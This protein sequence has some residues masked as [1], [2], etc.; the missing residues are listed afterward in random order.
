MPVWLI[1]F[2]ILL[3]RVVDVSIGTLRLVF[4]SRG[5][6]WLAPLAG[7]FEVLIWITAIAQIMRNLDNWVAYVA[8]AGGFAAGTWIGMWFEEKLALGTVLL[9][10]IPQADPTTLAGR[11][12]DRGYR[13]TTVDA[14]GLRGP[15]KILFSVIRRTDLPKAL[16]LVRTFN[17][18]AF[19][20]IEDVRSANQPD[21][22][23][24]DFPEPRKRFFSWRLGK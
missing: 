15:V 20:T 8:Y 1:P 18:R 2:L 6:K 11:L 13:V 24:P 21:P 9:R 4:V 5:M 17:P 16:A 10:I 12:R 22:T 14:E 23:V 3:A 19:Y 7:F